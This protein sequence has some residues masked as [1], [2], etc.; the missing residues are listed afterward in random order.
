MNVV[1]VDDEKKALNLLKRVVE[2]YPAEEEVSIHPF[3][4]PHE[5]QE[6]ILNNEAD[7][8][9]MD[10][11]MPELSGVE[12][13]M[14][15]LAEKKQLPEFVFVTAYPEYSMT[16]WQMEAL[17]YIL[18]P[19]NPDQI[20]RVIDKMRK[21]KG[22]LVSNT[23]VRVQCFPIFDVYVNN[24]PL[25]FHHQK[26]KELLALLVHRQGSWVTLDEITFMLLEQHE[27]RSAKRY[28]R[29]ILYRLRQL[30]EQSGIA[31]I[32]ETAHGKARIVPERIECDYYK[33][34]AGQKELYQGNYLKEYQWAEED[35]ALMYRSID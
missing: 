18:K 26:S 23:S 2:D 21:L 1:I 28:Y 25:D 27:E 5:A 11:E 30:L 19:Y 4:N 33:Y 31:D 6:F 3:L 22:A 8:V 35:N 24:R 7:I 15:L 14:K 20:Y 29:I 17:G 13:M 12:I 34:L 10:I 32:I 16:A 9:F